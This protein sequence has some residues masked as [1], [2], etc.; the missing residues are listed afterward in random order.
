MKMQNELRATIDGV[1]KKIN[2]KEGEQVDAFV[3]IVE[4]G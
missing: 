3:P 1:V 2:F 4:L